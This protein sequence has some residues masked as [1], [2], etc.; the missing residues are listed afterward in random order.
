M[1][2]KDILQ[3][4]KDRKDAKKQAFRQMQEQ[5]QMDTLLHERKKSSNL[6]EL[7]RFDREENEVIIKKALEIARKKRSD[8]INFNHNPIDT[9]NIMKAEW[10]VLKEENQF[11]GKRNIFQGQHF[12]HKD[13][14]NLLRSGNILNN[15]G[16]MLN[17]GNMFNKKSNMFNQERNILNSHGGGLI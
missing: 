7:E 2:V 4:I 10:E 6:R 16:N 8:D 12:I 17:Q 11:S 1:G 14:K 9:A 13:N 5:D 3:N 15:K